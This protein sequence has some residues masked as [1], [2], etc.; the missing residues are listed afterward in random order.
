MAKKEPQKHLSSGKMGRFLLKRKSILEG[1]DEIKRSTKSNHC[2]EEDLDSI[3]GIFLASCFSSFE[4]EY[5]LW[6]SDT[7]LSNAFSLKG[8]R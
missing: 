5:P 8:G 6:L 2:Q 1:E 3:Q 7:G 4:W